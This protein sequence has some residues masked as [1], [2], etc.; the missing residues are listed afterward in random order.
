M[1]ISLSKMAM[2]C[3]LSSAVLLASPA[4]AH[5]LKEKGQATEVADSGMVVVPSR[6]WNRLSGK[7]GKRTETWTLD[8]GQ[9]NDVTFFGG[10]QPGDPLVKERS[11]KHD[12]LPKF[13][14]NTLLVEIPEL[15]EGTYRTYKDL[16]TF[17]LLTV[18]PT[19]FLGTDG[20]FFAYQYTDK[21]HLTRK[22]EARATII[23][24]NLYMITFDAPR[25]HYFEKIVRDFRSL[26]DTA[27]MN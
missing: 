14:K 26:A 9:L 22:G 24:G 27:R 12:P 23:D 10:I 18:E 17:E 19:S 13:G 20:V 2:L 8:G 6:D 16:A 5:K 4:S 3:A 15:L 25:L 11:K 7:I 1:T 21:D